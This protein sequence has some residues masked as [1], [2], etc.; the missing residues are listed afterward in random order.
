MTSLHLIFHKDALRKHGHFHQF[1]VARISG[2]R[3]KSLQRSHRVASA[4]ANDVRQKRC[5]N[6]FAHSALPLPKVVQERGCHHARLNPPV[7]LLAASLA[8]KAD[9]APFSH[10]MSSVVPRRSRD[11]Q[12]ITE[13]FADAQ[14]VFDGLSNVQ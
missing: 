11:S 5:G 2:V 10:S 6:T 13:P 7:F 14:K 12:E 3:L 9:R 4:K 1:G 8:P